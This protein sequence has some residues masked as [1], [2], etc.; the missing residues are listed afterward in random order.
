MI[1]RQYLSHV[2]TS[3][4]II[5]IGQIASINYSPEL[6]SREGFQRN[7]LLLNYL[8]DHCPTISERFWYKTV[9][10]SIRVHATHS[11]KT[12]KDIVHCLFC[13]RSRYC[14]HWG[15]YWWIIYGS[16]PS[17]NMILIQKC[18]SLKI[19]HFSDRGGRKFIVLAI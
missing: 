14:H 7:T 16:K 10:F 19:H 18:F 11:S 8:Y 9:F 6:R 2:E 12:S 5:T 3:V 13:K 17:G 15:H 4:L 1:N